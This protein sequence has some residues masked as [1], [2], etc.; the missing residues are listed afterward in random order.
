MPKLEKAN[1]IL[2]IIEISKRS[3]RKKI[4]WTKQRGQNNIININKIC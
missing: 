2:K 1:E 3:K 4:E